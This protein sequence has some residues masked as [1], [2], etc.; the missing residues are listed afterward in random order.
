M[1]LARAAGAR[2]PTSPARARMPTGAPTPPSSPE[3]APRSMEQAEERMRNNMRRRE[4]LLRKADLQVHHDTCYC[5]KP[6]LMLRRFSILQFGTW[7]I[8]II[9]DRCR[10]CF[11]QADVSRYRR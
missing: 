2:T 5:N 9:A 7:Q 3:K 1:N 11:V 6:C 4:E 10:L 8:R